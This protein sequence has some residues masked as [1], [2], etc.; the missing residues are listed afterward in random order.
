MNFVKCMQLHYVLEVYVNSK[1]LRSKVNNSGYNESNAVWHDGIYPAV[2]F[3]ITGFGNLF[4]QGTLLLSA[5][6]S[7]IQ[8]IKCLRS[9]KNNRV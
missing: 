4:R 7:G 2:L 3:D 9:T 5:S 6:S 1:C 8:G